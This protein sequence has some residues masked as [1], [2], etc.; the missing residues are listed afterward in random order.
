MEALAAFGLTANVLQAVD[1]SVRALAKFQEI[2]KEG[3]LAE[4]RSTAEISKT[5]GKSS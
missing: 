5:L 2:H 4:H 1:V 3:S